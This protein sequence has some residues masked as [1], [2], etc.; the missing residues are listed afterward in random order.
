MLVAAVEG[1]IPDPTI[2]V[3][4]ADEVTLGEAIRRITR[5]AGRRPAFLPLPV[6]AIRVLGHL[7]EWTMVTPLVAKAQARMLAEG[8]SEPLPWAP[9]APEG[10]RPSL[11]FSDERIRAAL[12]EGGF[13][14]DDLRVVRR[15]RTRRR[16]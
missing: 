6:W 4:G 2:A 15:S 12:P 8:V 11:P 10:I 7:A 1:R 3:M 9:E 14:L 13:G 16:G 5:V